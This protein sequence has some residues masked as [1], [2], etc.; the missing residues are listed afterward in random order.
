MY[1]IHNGKVV[2]EDAII[3]DHAVLVKKE[4]IQAIIHQDQVGIYP[5]AKRIDARGGYISPGFNPFRLY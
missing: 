5:E 2:T 1:I 3:E 4:R